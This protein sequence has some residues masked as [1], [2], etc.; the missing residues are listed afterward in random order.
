MKK[1]IKKQ[2]N[3]HD[4]FEVLKVFFKEKRTCTITDKIKKVENKECAVI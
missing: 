1:E 2:K 3:Y 4:A